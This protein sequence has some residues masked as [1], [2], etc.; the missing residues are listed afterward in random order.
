MN[1][2]QEIKSHLLDIDQTLLNTLSTMESVPGLEGK[3]LEHFRKTAESI[4]LQFEDETIR[5]AVVGAIKS[6]KSTCINAFLGGDYLKRGAGVVTSIVTRI[7]EGRQL[8]AVMEVK[9][10]EEIHSE[11][12]QACVLLPNFHRDDP[13]APLDL[14]NPSDRHAL[15]QALD[16]LDTNRLIRDGAR[17]MN[18]V[19]LSCYL[20]GYERMAPMVGNEHE[21]LSFDAARF[22]DHRNYVADDS[23]A[24]YL[25]DISL[26]IDAERLG[27]MI[28]LADCQGSDS[29]NPLHLAMIQDYLLMTHFIVYVISSRTG[30]RRADIRFLSMI[31]KMGILDNILFVVNWD[32]S[33]HES[34]ETLRPLIDKIREEIALI[35]PNP[36]VFTFSCLYHL[37][38]SI[39]AELTEKDMARLRQW[40]KDEAFVSFSERELDRFMDVFYGKIRSQTYRLL[41]QNPMDRLQGILSA[42]SHWIGLHRN[43]LGQDAASAEL[44]LNKINRHQMRMLQLKSTL[45]STLD[46]HLAKLHQKLRV[47]VDGFF[48]P[49]AEGP[50]K[51]MTVCV[52]SYRFDMEGY[53]PIVQQAGFRQALYQAYQE[54]KQHLDTFV[55]ENVTPEVIRFTRKIEKMI[56]QSFEDL[57]AP[58]E[59]LLQEA[60]AEYRESLQQVGI[61][62]DETMGRHASRLFEL[63]RVKST[64][65]IKLPQGEV[66]LRYSARIQSEAVL[67]LGVYSFLT[68]IKRVLKKPF[69]SHEEDSLHAL[70]GAVERMKTETLKS[71][72]SHFK[73]YRENIKFQYVLKLADRTADALFDSL[74]E[75]FQS[76]ATDISEISRFASAH[77]QDKVQSLNQL[78]NIQ[79]KVSQLHKRVEELRTSFG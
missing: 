3:N 49:R 47:Q 27:G 66:A 53:H 76:Y 32:F 56:A 23:L 13:D 25:R 64:C 10:W 39:E 73:D 19:L 77:Q 6:G 22:G 17:D 46:G 31:Q 11:I 24:V 29:P 58:F 54:F 68:L 62:F 63:D 8:D 38:R 69:H 42:V 57:A 1:P 67:R 5:I 18:A 20:K 59:G 14:R 43:L 70:R 26:R 72:I 61:G 44:V 55:S 36:E 7:R 41:L 12:A 28:E 45:R 9:S 52:D 75:K 15:Q 16:A 78:E 2:F 30:L 79:Q 71:L 65:G 50:M 21:R 48:D 74:V 51:A 34:L 33:E 40:S 4:R 60:L 37:F 35:R